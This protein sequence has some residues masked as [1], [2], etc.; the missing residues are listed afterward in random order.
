LILLNGAP[1]GI[2]TPDL[3]LRRAIFWICGGLLSFA[4]P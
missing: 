2:R 3:C 4:K 1:E